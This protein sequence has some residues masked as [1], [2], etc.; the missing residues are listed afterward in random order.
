M[1]HTRIGLNIAG[2]LQGSAEGTL[3]VIALV[4]IVIVIVSAGIF[5]RRS[6]R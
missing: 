3:G 6:A 2:L 4:V 1:E 5:A